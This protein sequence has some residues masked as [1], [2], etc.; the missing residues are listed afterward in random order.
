MKKIIL[1]AFFVMF[2]INI[3]SQDRIIVALGKNSSFIETYKYY[4]FTGE[5]SLQNA[6]RLGPTALKVLKNGTK[7]PINWV[8]LNEEHQKSFIKEICRFKA[9]DKRTFEFY[10][11]HIDQFADEIVMTFYGYSDG[12]FKITIEENNGIGTFITITETNMLSGFYDLLNGKSANKEID[13]IF[14]K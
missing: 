2:S 8:E 3:M 11:R 4:D 14:K 13:D 9:T 1:I 10:K 7:T 5:Y 6:Y 12:T